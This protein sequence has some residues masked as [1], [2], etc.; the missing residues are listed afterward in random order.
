MLGAIAEHYAARFEQT[1][2]GFKWI[3]NTALELEEREGV[4]TAFGYEEALGYSVGRVVRDKDGMSAALLLADLASHCKATETTLLERLETLY[5]RH[6][7]WVSVQKSIT[8]PGS[9]GH[10]QIVRAMQR[11]ADAP[12]TSLAGFAVRRIV[13]YRT[14][15]E[16]RPHWLPTANLVAIELGSGSRV[17]VRPSGTEPK[18]KIYVDLKTELG[19]D[20]RVGESE[21]KARAEAR[22]LADAAAAHVGLT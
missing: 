3:W 4:R 6:G 8:L 20:D 10:G 9:E 14:G 15:A 7:L 2:T 12:P 19:A 13:D 21:E 1:L 17:L 16:E 22:A 18:L 5:R 11:L